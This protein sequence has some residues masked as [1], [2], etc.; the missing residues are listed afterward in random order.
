MENGFNMHINL[1][2]THFYN[3]HISLQSFS[4]ELKSH[5]SQRAKYAELKSCMLLLKESVQK[6]VIVQ[7]SF[8]KQ[9]LR[10]VSITIKSQQK[11][12]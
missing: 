1:Y 9:C 3:L 5:L 4:T 6:N 8:P 12:S 11:K 7:S 2:F 10:C